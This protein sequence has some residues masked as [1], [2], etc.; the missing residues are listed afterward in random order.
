MLTK[1]SGLFL[2]ALVMPL[3]AAPQTSPDMQKI[4]ERLD[5]LESE[6]QTLLGEIRE[7]RGELKSA[8]S[9][10]LPAASS[11]SHPMPLSTDNLQSMSASPCRRAGPLNWSNRRSRRRR[12]SRFLSPECSSSMRLQMAAI[13][14]DLSF[15]RQLT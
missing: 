9:P 14:G 4:L 1:S 10:D 12:G 5:K 3:P 15:P 11:G 6:N 13:A 8:R 7:L 2:L